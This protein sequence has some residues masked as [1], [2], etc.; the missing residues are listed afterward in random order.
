MARRF[1]ARVTLLHCYI[2]PPSFDFAVGHRAIEERSLHRRAVLSRFHK[3]GAEV[4][5]VFPNCNYRFV[6]GLPVTQILRKS[7]DLLA[8]LIA[9]PLPLDLVSWC[10]L[11][12]EL[13]GELVSRAKCPVLCVPANQ[14]P[15]QTAM[16]RDQDF[17]GKLT[18]WSAD[19]KG[20]RLFNNR[21]GA[22]NPSVDHL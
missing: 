13:L 16:P 12:E 15:L 1:G 21:G 2:V 22:E 3:L 10:Y 4:R 19:D 17:P 11:P 20:S 18:K 7:E 8:D 14:E 5:Q 9:I 6:R